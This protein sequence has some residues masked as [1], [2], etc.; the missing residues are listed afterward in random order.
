MYDPVSTLF[1][2][3]LISHDHVISI[4]NYS[5]TIPNNNSLTEAHATKYKVPYF[6]L[7]MKADSNIMTYLDLS[8]N[9]METIGRKV[10]AN[11]NMIIKLDLSNNRLSKSFRSMKRSMFCFAT[12]SW[13]R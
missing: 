6:D 11:L 2:N 1:A 3:S 10:F 8:S 9:F 7:K 5:V 4:I 13:T 12:Q